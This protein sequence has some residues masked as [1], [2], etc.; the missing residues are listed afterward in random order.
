MSNTAIDDLPSQQPINSNKSVTTKEIA[1]IYSHL[2]IM[3][4]SAPK[5][6]KRISDDHP[7]LPVTPTHSSPITPKRPKQPDCPCHHILVSKDSEHCALCDDVIPILS[8]M[9]QSKEQKQQDLN[10]CREV[11]SNE[12]KRSE[13]LEKEVR[14][15]TTDCE[16]SQKELE[17]KSK[18]YA[19]LEKDLKVLQ[20]KY[21]MEKKEAE[22]AKQ[23]K[24]DV[25][26]ELEELSQKLFEE[27]N[28]MVANEKREKH[29][30]Q[31][32]LKHLQK[33]LKHCREQM[34]AEEMQ[35]KELKMK[36]ARL[37]EKRQS[38][39]FEDDENTSTCTSIEEEEQRE[40]VDKKACRDLSGL[41]LHRDGHVDDDEEREGIEPWVLQE[42]E[43]LVELGET[44]PI[45]KLHSIAYMKHSL[46]EDIEPCLRFGPSSRLAPRKLYEAMMLNTCFIEEAP[47]GYAQDQAKRPWDV[48]LRIS[49][50]K[51][52]IWER[53]SSSTTTP[54]LPFS[55]CQACGRDAVELPYRFRISMLDDWACIDRHCRDRL[56][57]ACEFYV[58]I[59]NVRQGYYNGRSIPDL[60][61]ESIRLKLQMFYARVGTLSQTLHNM[62]SKGDNIG[63]ASGPN[64]IIPPPS[65]TTSE[66]SISYDSDSRNNSTYSLSESIQS[67]K[68]TR[69]THSGNSIHP[70]NSVWKNL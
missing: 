28:D 47:Y 42:F 15:M 12:K 13:A 41:L 1:N 66:E 37:N 70:G 17:E 67:Q 5:S 35:L 50:G 61:Q 63:H 8:E 25:E 53:L 27:A 69:E 65:T 14:R 32:Q 7:T 48:P 26:N 44:V 52:M 49:A 24:R 36:M 57:S 55:G 18:Q 34:D 22:K 29:Q 62:G 64:M 31:V 6:P 21:E 68:D 58:F 38:H 33:E 54:N 40:Y 59:R 3:M 30:I 39:L 4:E 19:S 51:S 45:R 11:L 20:E 46:T 16:T 2:Q 43:D 56:V 10:R 23:A 60:Y 9:Q